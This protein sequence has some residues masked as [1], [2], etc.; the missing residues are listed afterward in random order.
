[1]DDVGRAKYAAGGVTAARECQPRAAVD[2][3]RADE[4]RRAAVECLGAAAVEVQP[5][6]RHRA[7]ERRVGERG[8]VNDLRSDEDG[9]TGI[10]TAELSHANVWPAAPDRQRS[11]AGA[12]VDGGVA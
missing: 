8:Y 11:V 1:E 10:R 2:G 7:G 3:N 4:W 12:K 5:L 6:H 9:R